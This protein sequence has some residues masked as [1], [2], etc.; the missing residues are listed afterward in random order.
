MNNNPRPAA[1]FK[2]HGRLCSLSPLAVTFLLGAATGLLP[3]VVAPLLSPN[4][5]PGLLGVVEE[6]DL[7]SICQLLLGQLE[8]TDKKKSGETLGVEGGGCGPVRFIFLFC[9]ISY[10]V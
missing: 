7:R 9:I 6:L 8:V 2:W 10:H 1:T 5:R 4:P 3:S